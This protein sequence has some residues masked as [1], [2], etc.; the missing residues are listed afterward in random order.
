MSI[1]YEEARERLA[2]CQGVQEDVAE[3]VEDAAVKN[4]LEESAK[5]LNYAIA[6]LDAMMTNNTTSMREGNPEV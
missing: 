2:L 3:N 4:G 5:Y 1:T 6:R